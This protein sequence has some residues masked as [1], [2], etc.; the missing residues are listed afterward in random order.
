MNSRFYLFGAGV[1]GLSAVLYFG[2]D[3]IISVIDNSEAMQA[4]TI[5][6]IPVI[7]FNRFIQEYDGSLVVIS[8]IFGR[9][10]IT[11]QLTD[12][13]IDNISFCPDMLSH[14]WNVETI[15]DKWKLFGKNIV[16]YS[17]HPIVDVLVDKLINDKRTKITYFDEINKDRNVKADILL[18]IFVPTDEIYFPYIK[19]LFLMD[20]DINNGYDYSFWKD[21]KGMYKGRRCFIVGNGPSLTANDLTKIYYNNDL[22]IACN[23]IDKVY[24]ETKWRPSYYMVIDQMVFENVKGNLPKEI[25][26]ILRDMPSVYE[27]VDRE[28]VLLL[29]TNLYDKSEKKYFSEDMSEGVCSGGTSTFTMLQIMAYMGC[30]ELILLGV[31][32]SW[33]EDGRNAHFFSHNDSKVI[34]LY[35][36]ECIKK[37]E[38]VY[39]SYQVA[40][41]YAKEHGITIYNATRGGKLD[42]FPRVD[43]D[44][45]F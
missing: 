1:N 5:C 44:S 17:R 7:S 39:D 40:N 14:L 16:V 36:S 15:I 33:G 23:R 32:F 4:S 2:C 26:I 21:Y 3:R 27:V 42:I 18:G 11:Q 30:Q 38:Y 45:L 20:K 12:N 13:G 29:R 28:N 41:Q 25:P 9:R 31:D 34:D 10:E 35:T 6:G 43:F 22:S 8:A 19:H 24:S 37:K